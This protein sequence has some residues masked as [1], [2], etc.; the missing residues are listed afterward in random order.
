M[1][2]ALRQLYVLD[3]LDEDGGITPL[4][5]RMARLPLDPSLARVLAAAAE[6]GCLDEALSV[7]AMLSSDSVFAGNR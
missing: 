6:L 3:C 5:E 1:E 4:G 2:D 7:C